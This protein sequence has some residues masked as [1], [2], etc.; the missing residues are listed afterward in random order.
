MWQLYL[1]ARPARK[2]VRC[3]APSHHAEEDEKVVLD[4]ARSH[5]VLHSESTTIKV[6]DRSEAQVQESRVTV[7]PYP[8]TSRWRQSTGRCRTRIP[9][10]F[11]H[12]RRACQPP[13][14]LGYKGAAF[15]PVPPSPGLPPSLCCMH[16]CWYL[17]HPT[18]P[19]SMFAVFHFTRPPDRGPTRGHGTSPLERATTPRVSAHRVRCLCSPTRLRRH[20]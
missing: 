2:S 1:G 14:S 4:N 11:P 20:L 5:H 15:R 8:R 16:I 10:R 12:Q 18:R 13:L 19:P 6:H 3:I 7:Q 9:V 17:F